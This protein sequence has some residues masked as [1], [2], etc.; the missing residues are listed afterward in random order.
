MDE[1]NGSLLYV[2]ADRDSQR[3]FPM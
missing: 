2:F 1:D 3:V